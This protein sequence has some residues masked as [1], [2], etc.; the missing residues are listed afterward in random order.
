MNKQAVNTWILNI[1]KTKNL[2]E[3]GRKAGQ[4]Q[5]FSSTS[6]LQLGNKTKPTAPINLAI[7]NLSQQF[8]AA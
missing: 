7:A 4:L 8:A 6:K 3:R 5:W 2:V 1:Q